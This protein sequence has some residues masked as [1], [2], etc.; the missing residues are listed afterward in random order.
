MTRLFC[1]IG[2]CLA[3]SSPAWAQA[4]CRE[5][6]VY[7]RGPWGQ[8]QFSVEIADD[9]D[10]RAQGLM[11]RQDLPRGAGMLFIYDRPQA[12]SFWMQNTLIP[13]DMIFVDAQGVVQKIHQDAVP[14][15]T[16]GIFGGDGIFAVLEINAGLSALY[17]MDE[18]TQLRHP[19]FEK[20]MAKWP[21]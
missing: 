18:G 6:T 21:C 3:L 4:D 9:D 15:D 1:V 7:L 17:G 20:D 13:L 8:A 12:V 16:T 19:R 2:F 14:M 10:E 5:D 11:H